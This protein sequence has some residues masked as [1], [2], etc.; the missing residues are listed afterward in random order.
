M[1]T[2]LMRRISA[3]TSLSYIILIK[4]A[5]RRQGKSLSLEVAFRRF[6]VVYLRVLPRLP[7]KVWSL[8]MH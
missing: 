4:S 8:K 2:G 3:G 1:R 5:A 6:L 7:A